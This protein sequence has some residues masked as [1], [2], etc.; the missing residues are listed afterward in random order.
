M[1][2]M[3]RK[4]LRHE[5]GTAAVEFAMVSLLFL[6]LL[7]GTVEVGRI[8][9]TWNALQYAVEETARYAAVHST[10]TN[11]AL[12]AYAT[13]KMAGVSVA[14]SQLTV[15]TATST[16]SGISFIEVTGTYAFATLVPSLVPALQSLSLTAKSKVPYVI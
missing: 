10:A 8:F 9:W 15:T 5:K 4:Y 11:S 6:A 7:L 1:M 3:F 14:T 12:V 2:K 16:I 13:T